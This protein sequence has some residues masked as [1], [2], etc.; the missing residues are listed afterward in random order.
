MLPKTK[1]QRLSLSSIQVGSPFFQS[2]TKL[3]QSGSLKSLIELDLSNTKMGDGNA[4][5][6]L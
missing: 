6:L 2:L 1:I 3:I 5:L 4:K